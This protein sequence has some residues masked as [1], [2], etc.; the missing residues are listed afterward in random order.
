[1]YIENLERVVSAIYACELTDIDTR[2]T[3]FSD[4]FMRIF[5]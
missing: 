5:R 1:M 2:V 3:I 4:D